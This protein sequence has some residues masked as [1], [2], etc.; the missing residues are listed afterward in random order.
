MIIKR[1]KSPEGD[2]AVLVD[3]PADSVRPIARVEAYRHG[4]LVNAGS[5]FWIELWPSALLTAAHVLSGADAVRIRARGASGTVA[6]DAATYAS[7][8]GR[9]VAV[10]CPTG[11]VSVA[12]RWLLS[13]PA[14]GSEHDAAIVG[15]PSANDQ[16]QEPP[17]VLVRARRSASWLRLSK[18]G[19]R[20]MSGGPLVVRGTSQAIGVYVGPRPQGGFYAAATDE[21]LFGALMTAA[22]E[23][24]NAMMENPQ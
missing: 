7:D 17:Q 4:Q 8:P 1:L 3:P 19:V 2:A 18:A 11:L 5:A 10:L 20:A 6:F 12:E 9:D 21:P 24:R 15:Y 22:S 23:E 16:D 13:V 14:E